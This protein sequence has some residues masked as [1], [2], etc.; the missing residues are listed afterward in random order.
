MTKQGLVLLMVGG[1]SSDAKKNSF[2]GMAC[3]LPRLNELDMRSKLQ[4]SQTCHYPRAF[5]MAVPCVFPI[6]PWTAPCMA[7]KGGGAQGT[8]KS[9]R[10]AEN[11]TGPSR[12]WVIFLEADNGKEEKP[13]PWG[14]LFRSSSEKPSASRQWCLLSHW[15]VFRVLKCPL[16]HFFHLCLCITRIQECQCLSMTPLYI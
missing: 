1:K 8:N 5:I 3:S 15:L 13:L 11:I 12:Q 14:R 4:P 16:W 2:I 9:E 10:D 6:H 7:W